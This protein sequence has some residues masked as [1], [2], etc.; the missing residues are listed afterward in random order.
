MKP[1]L[2]PFMLL[3]ACGLAL[4]IAAHIMALAGIPIPGGSHV[5]LLHIGIFIVWIP[6]VLVSVQMTRHSRRKD[7][8]KVVLAGCPVWVRRG[9]PILFGYVIIN[10]FWFM[11][12]T[13]DQ[14]K[15]PQSPATSLSDVR[16]FSGHWMMFYAAAL[17]VLYSRIH[18]PHLYRERK[19]PQG[20][21]ASPAAHFCSECGHDFSN[22]TANT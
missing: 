13:A 6:A 2:Y 17:A 7:H 8:L 14:P 5:W 11:V 9:F 22:E 21:T 16:G 12:A 18:A 20:H 1:I 15:Q 19:C 10:F 3:A 4:S